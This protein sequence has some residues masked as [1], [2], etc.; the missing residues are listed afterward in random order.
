MDPEQDRRTAMMLDWEAYRQQLLATVQEIAKTAP[1]VV[2][3]YYAGAALVYSARTL[4]A[5]NAK[6]L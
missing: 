6:V 4:D 5:F 2:R 1:D 3:G